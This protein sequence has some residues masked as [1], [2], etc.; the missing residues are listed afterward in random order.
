MDPGVAGPPWSFQVDQPTDLA[1]PT[2]QPAGS[3]TRGTSISACLT[4]PLLCG[5]DLGKR[6]IHTPHPY[7]S[8]SIGL[9]PT[10]TPTLQVNVY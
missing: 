7:T 8:L 10:T 9:T 1:P 3:E 4:A 5:S 6:G 2:V